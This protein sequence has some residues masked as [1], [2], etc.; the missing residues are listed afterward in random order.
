MHLLPGLLDQVIMKPK[1]KLLFSKLRTPQPKKKA[2]T[3]STQTE[4]STFSSSTQTG[5]N[6]L[7]DWPEAD[8]HIPSDQ[9]F[10]QC[11][12]SQTLSDCFR[13][14][15]PIQ[16]ALIDWIDPLDQISIDADSDSEPEIIEEVY[17]SRSPSPSPDPILSPPLPKN[18][19]PEIYTRDEIK[20]MDSRLQSEIWKNSMETETR[21]NQETIVE[22]LKVLITERL[23]QERQIRHFTI[24]RFGSFV[25]GTELQDS[26]V[27]LHIQIDYFD[28]VRN[29]RGYDKGVLFRLR[30]A[31]E[32][33]ILLEDYDRGQV[34]QSKLFTLWKTVHTDSG[35]P[36]DIVVN[37]DNGTATSHN[38][39][40]LIKNNTQAFSLIQLFKIYLKRYNLIAG[41]KQLL[42]SYSA[43]ILVL[44]YLKIYPMTTS[45]FTNF[46]QLL[47]L[48]SRSD[49][50][51]HNLDLNHPGLFDTGSSLTNI[52]CPLEDRNIAPNLQ[53]RV[54]TTR[55]KQVYT[56]FNKRS[57]YF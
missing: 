44:I 30:E 55:L 46:H 28:R 20:T 18:R 36:I 14:P 15:T 48:Y 6:P 56:D 45:I 8:L 19:L 9:T 33:N 10:T 2:R 25:S 43:S 17:R 16:P 42:T 3:V 13:T 35:T 51:Q 41:E 57:N 23:D 11:L 40:A 47:A 53:H 50:F 38:L 4:R 1:A 24:E 29:T 5:Y 31:L 39:K 26:D 12:K 37:S 34:I 49:I 21:Q 7:E 27:D 22:C 32:N 54:I 52:F